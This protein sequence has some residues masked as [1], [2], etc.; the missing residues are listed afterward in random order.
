MKFCNFEDKF[1][2]PE[3]EKLSY[4]QRIHK[5]KKKIASLMWSNKKKSP[6]YN[7]IK[8]IQA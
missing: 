5:K 1:E 3:K 4:S 2:K 6:R 7:I 8:Y